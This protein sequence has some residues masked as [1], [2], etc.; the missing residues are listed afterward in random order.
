MNTEWASV[1]L[2]YEV[3]R[4]V[5]MNSEGLSSS[6]TGLSMVLFG[7]PTSE[8]RM[9]YHSGLSECLSSSVRCSFSLKVAWDVLFP[10]PWKS[11]E[12]AFDSTAE[13]SWA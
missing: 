5:D 6:S 9:V 7:L 12:T 4:G 2:I 1:V 10:S 11:R 13:A 8:Q 3:G